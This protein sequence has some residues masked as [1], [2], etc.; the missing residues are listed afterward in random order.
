MSRQR[1]PK[2]PVI[3]TPAHPLWELFYNTLAGPGYCDFQENPLTWKCKGGNDKTFS[4]KILEDLKA[5][6]IPNLD[7]QGSL[8][9]FSEHGG[10]CDC[11][12]IFNVARSAENE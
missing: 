10:H 7:V 2:K 6:K 9:Y 3:M 8:D 5:K 1:H 4:S 12:V 11:E